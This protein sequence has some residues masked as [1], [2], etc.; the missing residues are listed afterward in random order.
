MKPPAAPP[1]SSR[2]GFTL[3]ELLVVIGI[4]AVVASIVG[5]GLGRGG[6]ATSLAAAQNM[7]MSQFA[8][9]RAQAALRGENA[10]LVVIDDVGDPH[11]SRRLVGVAVADEGLWRLVSDP[12]QLPGSVGVSDTLTEQ[13]L[14]TNTLAVA[15]DPGDA[16]T[17]CL[18]VEIAANGTLVKAGG[19]VVWLSI[20]QLSPTGWQSDRASMKRGLRV[21]RY[22]AIQMIDEPLTV[23]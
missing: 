17:I 15:V 3:V 13:S 4:M 9:T 2:R 7:M 16:T 11:R 21:S 1:Y 18:A 6:E 14:W 10:A 20:G 22:G 19:G 23:P 5:I 12:V 8:A